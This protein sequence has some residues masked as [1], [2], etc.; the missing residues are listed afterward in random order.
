M[1]EPG[2]DIKHFYK[3]A[4][5]RGLA[6]NN[7]YRVKS[8]GEIFNNTNNAD[9][10]IY[11]RDGIVPSRAIQTASINYKDFELP[12]PMAAKY[13]ENNS[14]SITF[15]CDKNYTLRTLFETWSREIY[16]EHTH[17]QKAG[18][19]NIEV[20]LLDNSDLSQNARELKEIRSYFLVGAFPVNVGSMQYNVGSTG[21]FVTL[22]VNLAFQY[23]ISQDLTLYTTPDTS[24]SPAG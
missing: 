17:T 24:A 4:T 1:P 5:L 23:V 22:P 19:S 21:E 3:T 11:A 9:L 20:V 10:L 18:L 6:R 16:D 2:Y 13:P 12:V 14:W 7:L 8:I 15:Y